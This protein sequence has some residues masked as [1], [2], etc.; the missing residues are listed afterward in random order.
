MN[1]NGGLPEEAV[2]IC[3]LSAPWAAVLS[4]IPRVS[5]K[6]STPGKG[7]QAHFRT[8]LTATPVQKEWS[9]GASPA[10]TADPT[11][12]DKPAGVPALGEPSLPDT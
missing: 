2:V 1:S 9:A 7:P 5:G 10:M 11:A 6:V 8:P 12:P 3:Y 4:H